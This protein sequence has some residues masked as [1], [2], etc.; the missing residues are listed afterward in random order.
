MIFLDK[1]NTC[2]SVVHF[3]I[4]LEIFVDPLVW[5][6]YL[7]ISRM[8]ENDPIVGYKY[9]VIGMKNENDTSIGYQCKLIGKIKQDCP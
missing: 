9:T 3:K 4:H 8:N 7:Y 5:Y 6:K 1:I 2:P